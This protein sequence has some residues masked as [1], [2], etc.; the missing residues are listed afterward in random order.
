[1]ETQWQR[2]LEMIST[3]N[4]DDDCADRHQSM[5]HNHNQRAA[6][7]SKANEVY[8]TPVNNCVS[9]KFEDGQC[10]DDKL[11]SFIDLVNF[12]IQILLKTGVCVCVCDTRGS[13]VL[14]F[15]H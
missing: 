11:Q 1:M 9:Q 8:E 6:G 7:L 13:M 5:R 2:A 10:G 3:G 4:A 14:Q 12:F 15:S